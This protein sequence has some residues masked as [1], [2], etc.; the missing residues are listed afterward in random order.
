MANQTNYVSEIGMQIDQDKLKAENSN[1]AAAYREKSRKHQQ[2]QE[3]YDR[4]KRKEMTAV[5]Q[6]AAYD[7]VDDVIQSASNRQLNRA[8]GRAYGSPMKNDFRPHD[9]LE[10]YLPDGV[11]VEQRN[12]DSRSNGSGRSG[13]MMP[14]PLHRPTQGVANP[15]GFRKCASLSEESN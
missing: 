12:H 13:Q 8:T 9:P 2:T 1:L 5:T 4:L 10:Q 14:P 15:P 11:G 3:L 7:S 6:S